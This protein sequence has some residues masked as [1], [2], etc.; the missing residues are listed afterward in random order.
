MRSCVLCIR[1]PVH[2]MR[3]TLDIKT[4]SHSRIISEVL[5]FAAQVIPRVPYVV[6]SGTHLAEIRASALT[7]CGYK[8]CR[9][10]TRGNTLT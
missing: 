7:S 1:T 6:R 10:T 5:R 2:N 3:E 8:A 9:S 4:V